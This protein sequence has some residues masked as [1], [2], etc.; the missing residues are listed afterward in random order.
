V[1]MMPLTV[2]K[3]VHIRGDHFRFGFYQK[4]ITKPIFF[5]KNRNQFKPT[6]FRFGFSGRN[7]FKP[8]LL[9]FFRFVSVF[10]GLGWFGF[11]SFRL[12]KPKLNRTEPAGVF[13]ILISLIGFFSRF[14]F[15][16]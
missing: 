8:V 9:G 13:K 10:F 3:I 6:G 4:K 2:A 16:G 7:R 11:F 14:G 1:M 15:F 5:L 12:I